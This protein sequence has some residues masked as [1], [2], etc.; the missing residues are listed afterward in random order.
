[1]SYIFI[2]YNINLLSM[3][4]DTTGNPP[5]NTVF[6]NSRDTPQN[7]VEDTQQRTKTV[8]IH[9]LTGI[10]NTMNTCYM[11]SAIQCL[12]HTYP[13]T[14]YFFTKKDEI[15]QILKTNARNIFKDV[16]MFKLE[17]ANSP[18]TLE[19]RQKIQNPAYQPAMLTPDEEVLILNSTMTFKLIVL[20][21]NMWKRN[22]TVLPTSFRKI[23]SEARNKF[24]FGNE[25]HDAEE[26][27]SCILQKIQEELAEKKNVKFKT[28]KTSVQDF[29]E[30]KNKITGQLQATIDLDTRSQLLEVYKAKKREMP[31]ESLTIEAFREMKNYYGS[32]YSR[33]TEIF[34]GFLHS[35]TTCPEC[36][37]SS[38]KF[39]P[40]LHLS[41]P[42]PPRVSMPGKSLT[43]Y[44]CMAEYCKEEV[45]DENNL[46]T[47]EGCNKK[48]R[49]IKKLQVWSS[50]PVLVIQLKRFGVTRISKDSRMVVYP[51]TDLDISPMVSSVQKDDN[52]CYK[53]TLQ[54]VVNH[55]GGMQGGHYF[56]YCKDEDSGKWFNFDDT[57]VTEMPSPLAITQ[58]AYLL[59]YIRQDMLN[60]A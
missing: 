49:A 12:S 27:Y 40:F 20:L 22:C 33:I 5:S 50:P 46:F 57:S 44:D 53:Y 11:N 21:E 45:L 4:Q 37:F 47:C 41:L 18:I 34:S 7:L 29:L 30:F 42:M 14:T 8:V 55:V 2:S 19:L 38:N 48:V 23:F 56:S 26:A 15:I 31:A 24:F 39:D 36:K 51:A 28:T 60:T 59:F 16:P 43:I 58:S 1:M 35:S 10:V 32:S 52:K 6:I 3:N 9:G 13:I 25:Q 54:C 17:C